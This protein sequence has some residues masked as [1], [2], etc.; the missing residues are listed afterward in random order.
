[1]KLDALKTIAELESFL[2]GSQSVAFI[3]ASTKDERYKFVADMLTKFSYFR[4]KRYEKSVVIRF[5]VK[6]SGYSRQ[7]ITRMIGCYRKHGTVVRRQKT[8]NGFERRYTNDDIRLLAELD[9]RHDTPNGLRIKKLCE[10][11]YHKFGDQDYVR[12]SNISVSHIYNLRK[13]SGYGKVRRHF[14]KTKGRKGEYIGE[15][16][17]PRTNGRP[18]FIRIDT[19]H[20]GD[21]DGCKGVYHINAVDE[22]TQYEVVVSVEKISEAYLLPALQILLDAFPFKIMNFHSDNGS[23]YINKMV[24]NLLNK[25]KIGIV[26]KIS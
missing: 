17:K 19:V 4:L 20:Q 3:V 16:R 24:A 9:K 15:R 18:G 5:L 13:S 21:L 22:V 10:R 1:M 2:A 6:V 11:A 23:E 8:A 25:L 26:H 14:D 12:L 7:Q